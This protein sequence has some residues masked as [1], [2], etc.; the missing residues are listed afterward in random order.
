MHGNIRN[1]EQR[2]GGTEAAGKLGAI[3]VEH[4]I[5]AT[6]D[7]NLI[8]RGGREKQLQV[9]AQIADLLKSEPFPDTETIKE[10][11]KQFIREN[12]SPGGS[13]DLLALTY[14]LYF[15]Q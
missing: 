13:A 9:K 6:D 12:L 4:L 10:L 11:D 1:R 7:T 5:A 8:H 2:I 3:S 14:F 15:L